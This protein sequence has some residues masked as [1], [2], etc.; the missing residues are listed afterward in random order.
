MY[1]V[2]KRKDEVVLAGIDNYDL[3]KDGKKVI[4]RAGQANYGIVDAAAGK[5]VGDG[6]LNL[7]SLQVRVDP[8]EE[9]KEIFHEAWRVE[10]DFYWDP[11]MAGTDWNMIGKRYEALLPWVAHRSD[12]NYIIGEMIAELSTSHTYVNGGD[13]PDRAAGWHRPAGRRLHGRKWLL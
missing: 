8:R 6:K 13:V 1:D 12:L 4:Y 9:W 3:D 2:S 5:K 7:A 11:G 10:R